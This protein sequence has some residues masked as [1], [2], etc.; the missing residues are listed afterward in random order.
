MMVSRFAEHAFWARL[1]T[2]CANAS[3]AGAGP[4]CF[5]PGVRLE[6]PVPICAPMPPFGSAIAPAVALPPFKGVVTERTPLF[7]SVG[8]LGSANTRPTGSRMLHVTATTNPMSLLRVMSHYLGDLPF[9][10]LGPPKEI[11]NVYLLRFLLT[12]GCA[13]LQ[14]DLDA[15]V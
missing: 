13:C 5:V 8:P 3:G 12:H 14:V 2:S 11:R 10:G 4:C 1:A 6:L 9:P 7:G 15:M